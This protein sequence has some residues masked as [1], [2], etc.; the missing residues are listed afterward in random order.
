[1]LVLPCVAPLM[2]PASFLLGIVSNKLYFF[3]ENIS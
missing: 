2:W 1:M 3:V